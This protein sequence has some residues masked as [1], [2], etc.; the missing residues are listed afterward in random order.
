MMSKCTA[1][2]PNIEAKRTGTFAGV[3]T[4]F[5]FIE[6]IFFVFFFVIGF[7]SFSFGSRH[8]PFVVIFVPTPLPPPI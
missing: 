6:L 2:F 7:V 1:K 3:E 8:F 5:N 4:D